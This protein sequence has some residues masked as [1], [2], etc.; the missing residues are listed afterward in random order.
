MEPGIGLAK[1]W[2]ITQLQNMGSIGLLPTSMFWMLSAICA[3]LGLVIVVLGFL[4][5]GER[6]TGVALQL[7]A[8]LSFLLFW[9]AYTG[10]ALTALFGPTFQPLKQRAREFGLA[11]ASAHIA[12]I[13]LVIWLCWI[14]AAPPVSVFVFF[15]IAL[16]FTYA[17][18]FF[19]I[20]HLQ[21]MLGP[22]G[23]WFLRTVG[24]N[25]IA[26]A[27]AK[28]FVKDPLGGGLKHIAAYLPFVVL[29]VV[30][31]VLR[32]LASSMRILQLQKMSC[33]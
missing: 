10:G 2:R 22:S 28:D 5:A 33:S 31:P 1:L 14:G 18:A 17:L 4:G 7:T 21:R 16:I 8:R 11:F 15:G 13:G 6:G 23:W 9:L 20:G 3:S 19:S 26:Y 32:L 24:L 25:Y 30:G 27:F 12:H 29:A